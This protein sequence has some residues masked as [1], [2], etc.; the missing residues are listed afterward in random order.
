LAELK[1]KLRVAELKAFT[2]SSSF[3]GNM[4]YDSDEQ[5]LT[6]ILSGK[7]YQWCDVPERKFDSFMGAG[8]AGA[9]FNRSLKGQHDCATGGILSSLKSRISKMKTARK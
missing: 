4:R 6:G 9:Y 8:S 7:H 3:V 5:T 2:N 1:L